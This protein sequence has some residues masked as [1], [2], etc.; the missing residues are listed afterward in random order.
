MSIPPDSGDGPPAFPSRRRR[1]PAEEPGIDLA[2]L[3]ERFPHYLTRLHDDDV[4]A[5]DYVV[6]CLV[7]SI[8]GMPRELAHAIML[9]A[10]E[11][12]VAIAFT[13]LQ[14]EA[15]HFAARLA[16]YGLTVSVVPA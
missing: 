15:E 9:T 3:R 16:S 6:E 2:L 4:H 13:G 11:T 10:H 7:R 12:G 14:E 5:M 1:V 8:P